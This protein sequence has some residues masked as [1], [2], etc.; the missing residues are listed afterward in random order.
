MPEVHLR[1]RVAG[2]GLANRI[3]DEH[4]APHMLA[5]MRR[6]LTCWRGAAP[7]RPLLAAAASSSAQSSRALPCGRV[8]AA[9]MLSSFLGMYT[10]C[11]LQWH[12]RNTIAVSVCGLPLRPVG[13]SKRLADSKGMR[14]LRGLQRRST[15][16]YTRFED[17]RELFRGVRGSC[18]RGQHRM[19][20]PQRLLPALI[21][22]A[23]NQ[24]AF[25]LLKQHRCPTPVC[26]PAQAMR[27]R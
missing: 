5:R 4:C 20:R 13:P 22:P 8:V 3:R 7:A 23:S 26:W 17:R 27:T 24:S 19:P 10:T 6:A 21:R 14:G 15:R 18:R 9:D 25:I 11:E 1:R 2:S 16:S 12:A